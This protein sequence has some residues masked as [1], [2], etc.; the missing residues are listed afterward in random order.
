MERRLQENWNIVFKPR[1]PLNL[2]PLSPGEKNENRGGGANGHVGVELGFLQK[3][4]TRYSGG[5]QR[6]G[7]GILAAMVSLPTD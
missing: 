7:R 1:K 5:A 2:L 6:T 3:M 4:G